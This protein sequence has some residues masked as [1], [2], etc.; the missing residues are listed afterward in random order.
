MVKVTGDFFEKFDGKTDNYFL[1]V[2]RDVR[3]SEALH[4]L[5]ESVIDTQIVLVN[6]LFIDIDGWDITNSTFFAAHQP[7]RFVA[8]F[9]K[10]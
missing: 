1:D 9:P 7:T 3:T 2:V 6:D 5:F 10:D 4:V 8:A